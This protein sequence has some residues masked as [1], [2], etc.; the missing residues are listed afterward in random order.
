MSKHLF[1]TG[2]NTGVGK[3]RITGLLANHYLKQG[4]RVVT[5][6]W[7]QTACEE[8]DD[9]QTHLDLMTAAS[10]EYAA[11]EADR[12]PYR[13]KFPSAPHL[14]A[15][16]ENTVVEIQPIKDSFMRLTQ[17]FD[18]VIVEGS[19]GLLMPFDRQ[20]KITLAD[21]IGELDLE[22]VIVMDN[23]LGAI[24]H[25]LLT[26]EAAQKRGISIKG[27]IV[28]HTKPVEVPRIA[29]DNPKIIT[30]ITG[31]PIIGVLSWNGE[32]LQWQ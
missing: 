11:Y 25:T 23:I 1:V 31:V 12:C 26:I 2:T 19:G 4:E 13:L 16:L 22:L 27:F 18:R 28:N 15:E 32:D 29:Q 5:Q 14:A 30:A 3:T 8:D 7:V 21:M 20:A 10:E 24:N 9:C 17:A 6:K